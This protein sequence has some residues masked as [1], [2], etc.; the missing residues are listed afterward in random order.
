M[1]PEHVVTF[2]E[3]IV[4]KLL[5]EEYTYVRALDRAIMPYFTKGDPLC[6]H[7]PRHLLVWLF[8]FKR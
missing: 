7:A 2:Y 8:A 6:A 3:I 5:D 4:S 1:G